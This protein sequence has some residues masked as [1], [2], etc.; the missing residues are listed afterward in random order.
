MKII[1]C[2]QKLIKK[3]N[4]EPEVNIWEKSWLESWHANVFDIEGEQCVLVTNDATLY[5][6][7]ICGVEKENIQGLDFIINEYFFKLMFNN[8]IPQPLLE[9]ALSV[10]DDVVYT[11][12]ANKSTIA[13]MNLF[14]RRIEYLT[15][16]HGGLN[17][18][19]AFKA[20]EAINRMPVKA[21]GFQFPIDVFIEKLQNK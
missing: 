13:S 16:T 3:L 20:Q 1:R 7:F 18:G 11:K 5:S 9:K 4:I 12:S 8:S 21:I 14:K 17:N 10:G 19:G 6:L 15:Y 2:T